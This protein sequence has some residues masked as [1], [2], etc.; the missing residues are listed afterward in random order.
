MQRLPPARGRPPTDQWC[1]AV[2]PSRR[3]LR[4]SG[5]RISSPRSTPRARRAEPMRRVHA[6]RIP[7]SLARGARTRL[8]RRDQSR[9][10]RQGPGAALAAVHARSGERGR[11]GTAFRAA[12]KRPRAAM[13]DAEGP[14][15]L[16]P[17]H[18]AD[19]EAVGKQWSYRLGMFLRVMPVT[20]LVKGLYHWAVICG[21]GAPFPSGFDSYS[22]PYR[23]ATVFFAIIDLVAGVGLWLGGGGGG[24]GGVCPLIA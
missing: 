12:C 21:I 23:V 20:S 4:A 3:C 10:H 5:S 7:H 13:T 19:G 14:Q 1:R 11:G 17:V 2:R 15:I 18:A 9:D 16:E 6:H 24:G 22:T 8:L